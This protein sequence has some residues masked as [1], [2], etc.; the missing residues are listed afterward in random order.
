MRSLLELAAWLIRRFGVIP[1]YQQAIHSGLWII[2]WIVPPAV[3]RL[4]GGYS[5]RRLASRR[6]RQSGKRRKRSPG[7]A[8]EK[9][10]PGTGGRRKLVEQ[11]SQRDGHPADP[12]AA[13]S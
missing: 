7:T 13:I 5:E 12:G 6:G 9:Q 1:A 2:A 10:R 4:S 11:G 8:Q 3:A